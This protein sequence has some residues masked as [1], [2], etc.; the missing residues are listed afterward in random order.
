[1]GTRET[2][3][4][5]LHKAIRLD[6]KHVIQAFARMSGNKGKAIVRQKVYLLTDDFYYDSIADFLPITMIFSKFVDFSFK[7]PDYEGRRI[8]SCV[9]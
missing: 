2:A 4:K 9:K 3:D 5:G 6:R 7:T 8:S 1:M